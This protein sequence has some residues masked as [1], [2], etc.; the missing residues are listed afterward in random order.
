MFHVTKKEKNNKKN[1]KVITHGKHNNYAMFVIYPRT[2][3]S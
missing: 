3:H 2:S 1:K